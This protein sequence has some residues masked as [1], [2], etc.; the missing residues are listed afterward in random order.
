MPSALRL[1][2]SSP[3]K[4]PDLPPGVI[5][6]TREVSP[7]PAPPLSRQPS[8]P[9]DDVATAENPF[10]GFCGGSTWS[11]LLRTKKTLG[12][13]LF[14]PHSA[15]SDEPVRLEI[16]ELKPLCQ[17]RS[18]RSLKITGMLQSYQSYIWQT[19]WLNLELEELSLEMALEP[20][21]DSAIH[22]AQWK[23][24]GDGWKMDKKQSAEPVYQ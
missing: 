18:L 13:D 9:V 16:N 3:F 2:G 15:E 11:D 5:I 22:V 14:W 12:L 4:Q 8:P 24:I 19:A 23:L 10:I 7:S 21:I 6:K 17:F 20:K 1:G